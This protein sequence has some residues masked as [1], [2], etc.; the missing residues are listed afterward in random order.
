MEALEY[1]LVKD[2]Y[3]MK[4]ARYKVLL[5]VRC[6]RLNAL[7]ETLFTNKGKESSAEVS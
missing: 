2:D 7:L 4:I 3:L 1:L 6:F 5:M